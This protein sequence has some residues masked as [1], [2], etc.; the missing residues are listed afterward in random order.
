MLQSERICLYN[1]MAPHKI[2]KVLFIYYFAKLA[3]LN[4]KI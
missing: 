2:S 4:Y 3:K 1:K